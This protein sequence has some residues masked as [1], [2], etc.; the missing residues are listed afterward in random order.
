MDAELAEGFRWIEVAPPGSE[1]SVAIVAASSELPSGIDTGIRF[2]TTDAD[3]EHTSMA[4]TGR[5]RRRGPALA[6]G[7]ADVLVPGRRRQ[8]VLPRRADEWRSLTL[9]ASDP[10]GM[11]HGYGPPYANDAIRGVDPGNQRRRPQQGRHG[12]PACG[13][14]GRRVRAARTYIQSG[15]VLFEAA[16]GDKS[17]EDDIEAAREPVRYPACRRGAVARQLRTVVDEGTRRVWRGTRHLPLG[18]ALPEG[19]ADTPSRRWGGPPARG[20]RPG[21]AGPGRAL[22]RRSSFRRTQSRMSRIV[23]TP[24]YQR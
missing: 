14:R 17:L 4:Q 9:G 18:R 3:T 8:H 23:G 20:R 11:A 1:V 5:R 10:I 12:R 22:L 6:G 2:V 13:V 7:A 16:P 19:A 15:N 24:E 21:V